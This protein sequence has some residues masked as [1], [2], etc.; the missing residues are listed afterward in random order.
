MKIPAGV[1]TTMINGADGK[2]SKEYVEV[3]VATPNG[4]SN[5]LLIPV[6]PKEEP[7]APAPK[8]GYTVDPDSLTLA[9]QG[10]MERDSQ[11]TVTSAAFTFIPNYPDSSQSLTIRLKDTVGIVP[12][13][14]TAIFQLK[15]SENSVAQVT[16]V[17]VP[18]N[19]SRDG[20]YVIAGDLFRNF[21]ND[22]VTF[23]KVKEILQNLKGDG[24][25]AATV[26]LIP[27]FNVP[28]FVAVPV[29]SNNALKVNFQFKIID[30]PQPAGARP[31]GRHASTSRPRLFPTCRRNSPPI[32]TF[33]PRFRRRLLRSSNLPAG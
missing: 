9:Y 6:K 1:H 26:H 29:S 24:A 25:L 14:I 7:K 33:R 22:L 21:A 11:G 28:G 16:V 30:V 12:V 8:V 4:I 23:P 5:R 27:S 13:T 19:P 31:L 20:E 32:P 3:Y 17:P 2:K 10:T 15:T 18:T